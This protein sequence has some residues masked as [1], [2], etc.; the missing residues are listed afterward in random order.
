[1]ANTEGMSDETMASIFSLDADGTVGKSSS[2]NKVSSIPVG[3]VPRIPRGFVERQRMMDEFEM[4][5][6]VKPSATVIRSSKK[7]APTVNYQTSMNASANTNARNKTKKVSFD[8]IHKSKNEVEEVPIENKSSKNLPVAALISKSIRERPLVIQSASNNNNQSNVPKKMSR[9]KMRQT[10]KNDVNNSDKESNSND[11]NKRK[12]DK[13]IDT[14]IH[15]TGFPSFDIPVGALTRKGRKDSNSRHQNQAR[16]QQEVFDAK[17]RIKDMSSK[18]SN[19]ISAENPLS[20][21]NS[22]LANMTN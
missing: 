10:G 8:Q 7:I 18:N 4:G 5:G 11:E 1:M 2:G 12:N 16:Q 6:Q 21:S 13:S 15:K 9:F 17:S 20:E 3:G 14:P 19:N 22:I